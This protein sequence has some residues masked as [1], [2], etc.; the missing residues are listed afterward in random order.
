MDQA[1]KVE[2]SLLSNDCDDSLPIPQGV[3]L[4]IDKK[5]AHPKKGALAL[6]QNAREKDYVAVSENFLRK[7]G[8]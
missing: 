5:N 2:N 7:D 8:F 6:T 3:R 4:E 1:L